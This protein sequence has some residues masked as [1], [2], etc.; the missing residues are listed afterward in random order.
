MSKAAPQFAVGRNT[1]NTNGRTEFESMERSRQYLEVTDGRDSRALPDRRLFTWRTIVF[2]FL[3]SRRRNRRRGDDD[4]PMFVDWHHPWLFFLATGIMLLSSMDAFMTLQLIARGAVEVNPVMA[5]VMGDGTSTFAA[6][7]M[8]MT[9]VSLLILVSLSRLK[10][11]NL[12]RTGLTLTVF[13][14][15]YCCLVCYEFVLLISQL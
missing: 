14:S 10:L 6:T 7:K 1:N 3:R 11:F 2:G 5:A 13:F 4:D 8:A 9:G 12:F 15:F